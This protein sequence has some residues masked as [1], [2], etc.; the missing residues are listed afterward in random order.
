MSPSHQPSRDIPQF[1]YHLSTSSCGNVCGPTVVK[2]VAAMGIFETDYLSNA[3]L[4][5]LLAQHVHMF[6]E[7]NYCSAVI[8]FITT[9]T[10]MCSELP[11]LHCSAAAPPDLV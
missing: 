6:F 2:V 4:L 7:L 5:H 9:A 11:A 1:L 10:Q 8:A 3:S